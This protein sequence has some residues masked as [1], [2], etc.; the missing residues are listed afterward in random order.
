MDVSN[1]GQLDGTKGQIEDEEIEPRVQPMEETKTNN[2][3]TQPEKSGEGFFAGLRNFK[4]R[5]MKVFRDLVELK[6]KNTQVAPMSQEM[7]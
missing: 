1:K 5:K 6:N 4:D 7:V 2:L 3:E